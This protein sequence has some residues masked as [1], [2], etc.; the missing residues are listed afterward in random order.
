ML[1]HSPEKIQNINWME[2]TNFFSFPVLN[3]GVTFAIFRG[4]ANIPFCK[5]N[6]KHTPEYPLALQK[7]L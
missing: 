1:Q 7:N 6:Q 2:I 4:S 3:T 5:E